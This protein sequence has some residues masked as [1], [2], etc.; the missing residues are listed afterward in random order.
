MTSRGVIAPF[1]LIS[2]A[3]CLAVIWLTYGIAAA[4]SSVGVLVAGGFFLTASAIALFGLA[5]TYPHAHLG[6]CNGVTI[7]RLALAS[8]LVGAVFSPGWAPWPLFAIAGLA[9]ALDGLDGYLARRD[10]MESDF[11]ARF[12]MEVDCVLALSL[13]CL[14]F[15]TD[16]AGAYVLLL[17][18]PRY[19]FGVAQIFLPWMNATLPPRFSRKVVCVIQIAALLL[20]VFPPAS[21][22]L[23]DICAAIAA[24]A[25]VWSFWRD[26]LWLKQAAQA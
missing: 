25:L 24:L 9:F 17:G 14:A 15:Q 16:A 5:R 4:G 11:G 26:I 12:D 18:L 21:S 2:A 8:V 22:P 19:A 1:V 13:A 6:L 23:T 20:M 3:S 7:A 10:A